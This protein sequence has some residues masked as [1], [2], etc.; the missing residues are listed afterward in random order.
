ML[1]LLVLLQLSPLLM[2]CGLLLMVLA[3]AAAADAASAAC[4]SCY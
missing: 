2:A 3:S 1:S 4:W